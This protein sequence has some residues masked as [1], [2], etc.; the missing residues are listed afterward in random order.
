LLEAMIYIVKTLGHKLSS[1]LPKYLFHT[2]NN[3]TKLL[4]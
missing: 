1:P 4:D 3:I 2:Q